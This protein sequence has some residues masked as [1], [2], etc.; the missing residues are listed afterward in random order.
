MFNKGI[1][2]SQTDMSVRETWRGIGGRIWMNTSG[3][4]TGKM[5]KGR[6]AEMIVKGSPTDLGKRETKWDGRA[7]TRHHCQSLP[8]PTQ[9]QSTSKD[10][11][12]RQSRHHRQ[13]PPSPSWQTT[14]RDAM[15]EE[16]GVKLESFPVSR[17]LL[18][19]WFLSNE[20]K[21][22]QYYRSRWYW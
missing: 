19:S 12:S 7:V 20:L 22:I 9:R 10:A 8:S 14:P 4:L 16:V 6:R 1:Q 11:H 3:S 2:R 15:Q 18:K 17:L 13:S 5:E 21:D